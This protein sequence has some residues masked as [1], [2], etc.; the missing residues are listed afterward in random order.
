[1]ASKHLRADVNYAWPSAQVAVMGAKGA[2]EIIFRGKE[3]DART[4]EY[5]EKFANPMVREGGH[6]RARGDG[7]D[8]WCWV[9]REMGQR[10]CCWCDV[11][12]WGCPCR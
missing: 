10:G 8:C 9:W 5:T 1:M 7:V 3:V 4:L 6:T 12:P 11:D 2:V